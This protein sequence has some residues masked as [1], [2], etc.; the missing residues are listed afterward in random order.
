LEVLKWIKEGKSSWDISTILCR[1][2]RVVIWH[3]NNIMQ[4]LG[5]KNRTQA[6]AIAMRYQLID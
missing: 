2:E 1:S 6:I 3:A 5:A 4:K